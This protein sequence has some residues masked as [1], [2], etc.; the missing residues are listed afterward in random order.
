VFDLLADLGRL[1]EW[2]TSV[3][4]SR[5]DGP[6]AEGARIHERRRLMG[7]E[8]ETELEVDAFAPGRRF[9]VSTLNG[10][11][12]LSIDHVLKEVDGHTMLH[13]T[14]EAR[15]AGLLR[16]AGAAVASRARQEI[17][18]DFARLKELLEE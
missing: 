17:R 12:D 3:I 8:A 14:A 16:L 10:P 9:A 2:Q 5:S 7:R 4:E 15:P 11:V 6:L 1:P 18:R 13:V